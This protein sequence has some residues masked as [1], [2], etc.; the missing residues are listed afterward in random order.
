[1]THPQQCLTSNISENCQKFSFS[2]SDSTLLQNNTHFS[3]QWTDDRVCVQIIQPEAYSK[4]KKR[5]QE[6]H[7]GVAP[8][9]GI[10]DRLGQPW[11]LDSR[12][13][14]PVFF[15][16]TWIWDSTPW[17]TDSRYWIL[18]FVTGTWILDSTPW[19]TDSRY[20][21][22]AFVTGT[23]ILDSTPWIPDSRY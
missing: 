1:M 7:F 20:W 18:V 15:S 2:F 16:G 8:C 19:I 9:K 3:E 17:I 6:L 12:Y 11:I 23:W 5:K 10:Q 22:L 21:I 14:I 13:W 4:N